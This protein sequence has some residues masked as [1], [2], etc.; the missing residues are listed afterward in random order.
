MK[1]AFNPLAGIANTHYA[2]LL[3]AFAVVTAPVSFLSAFPLFCG[4]LTTV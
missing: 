2:P 1:T 3:A 4:T